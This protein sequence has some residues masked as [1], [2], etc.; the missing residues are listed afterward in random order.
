MRQFI[1]LT[2]LDGEQLLLPTDTIGLIT[3]RSC[4]LNQESKNPDDWPKHTWIH[5]NVSTTDHPHHFPMGHFVREGIHQISEA[6][7]LSS[8]FTSVIRP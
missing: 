1:R 7:R 4:Q 3:V 5:F 8:S 6:L 2:K